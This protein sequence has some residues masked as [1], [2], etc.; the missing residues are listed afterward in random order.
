MLIRKASLLLLTIS[1]IAVL[2]GC[3]G[4]SKSGGSKVSAADYVK[5]ICNA[6]GPFEKDVQTRSAALDTSKLTDASQGKQALQ[7]FLSAIV[8]DTDKAVST[9]KAAGTPDVSNG[10][11]ISA[12]L[13]KAFTALKGTLAQAASKASSLPTG[14]VTAF[15]AAAQSLGTSIQ[16]SMSSIGSS[17]NGLKSPALEQAA[18]KEP[19]CKS[20]GG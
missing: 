19:A 4:S 3:G 18:A 9:L 16:A 2:S 6:V 14:S 11:Q 7:G 17:L 20:L 12:A 1:L 13:V 5:S 15:K 10:S 8:A